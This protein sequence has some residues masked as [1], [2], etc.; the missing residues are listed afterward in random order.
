MNSFSALGF[1][2]AMAIFMYGIRLSRIG[3]QLLAGDRLRGLVASLTENRFAALVTGILI[4]LIFQSSTATTVM[5]VGFASSG[6]ITLTQAMG[7]I[8]GADIGTTFVVVLLSIR[9]IA[10]YSLILLV[11]GVF[12]DIISKRKST[13]YVSM[14]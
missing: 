5:L 11:L 10:D 6:A 8:L 2:G 7:V 3:V 1:L 9:H 4:T 14:V 13:R 12:L